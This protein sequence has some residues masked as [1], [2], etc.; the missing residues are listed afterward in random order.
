LLHWTEKDVWNFIKT[1]KIPYNPLYNK[2][3]LS[4]ECEVCPTPIQKT[5]DAKVRRERDRDREKI[6]EQLRALGYW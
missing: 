6:K 4:I 2:G 3:F 1:R 5:E